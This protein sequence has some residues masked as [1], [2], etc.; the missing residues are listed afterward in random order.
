MRMKAR[1]IVGSS[2]ALAL[3]AAW[4]A[5]ALLPPPAAAAQAQAAPA[6]PASNEQLL[7]D[8]LHYVHIRNDDLAIANAN[9]LLSRGLSP[10]EFVGLV[11]DSRDGVR[12][13]EQ[14]VRLA[15][16]IPSLETPA[17]AL[18]Q[19]YENGKRAQSR[20]PEEIAQSIAMLDGSAR[21]RMLARERLKSARE[22]AVPQ[23]LQ[24]LQTRPNPLLE[25]EVT[26][27]LRDMGADVIAPLTAALPKVDPTTQERICEILGGVASEATL[28]YLYELER[29]TTVESVK[30]AARRAIRLIAGAP[31]DSTS[32]SDRFERLA[33]RYY[34]Q[35]QSLTRFPDEQHQLLWTFNPSYGLFPTP[36]RTEVFHEMRAMEIAAHAIA[37][38]PS[39]DHAVSL[40]I[41][42]NLRRE[43]QTPAGWTNPAYPASRP[44][45]EYYAAAGGSKVLQP[46][47]ARALAEKDTRL[48]RSAIKALSRSAGGATLWEGVGADKPLVRA[49]LYP[50]RRVQIDAALALARANPAE[51]FE[52]ADRVVPILAAAA[53]DAATTYALILAPSEEDRQ[54]LQSLAMELGYTA[55]APAPSLDAARRDIAEAPAVDLILM[56]LGSQT[57]AAIN[58]ARLISK[59]QVAP[60]VAQAGFTIF[61]ELTPRYENDPLVSVA[62]DGLAKEQLATAI[63]ETALAAAG[64]PITGDEASDYMRNAL[65][66]LLTL[67]NTR[68]DAF[69]VREASGPLLAALAKQTGPTRLL[70]ADVL[71]RINQRRAQIAI[72]DA[73]IHAEADDRV[74]LLERVALS[75]RRFGGLLDQTQLDWLVDTALVSDNESVATAAAALMGSLNMPEL[76]VAPLILHGA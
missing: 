10:V 20:D 72:M 68:S 42:A 56:R 23:L 35:Q 24:V 33:E 61:N 36:V 39:N 25:A 21:G 57:Q 47:L 5:V 76:Q 53:A 8:F 75:V 31:D 58:N 17:A 70:V 44:G 59:L 7:A 64:P 45:A 67:A 29:T 63:L 52:G 55:I 26:R 48:A 74:A 38:D 41:A 37:L 30:G 11:E 13:F 9:A 16:A 46:V 4:S 19:L 32:L 43:I 49:L 2:L 34:A 14:T 65:Q 69:D 6:A 71:A 3:L 62:R 40:W 18:W 15:M 28:P 73:A 60:I 66:A 54:D 12:R 22:Y 50:D 1:R 51:T 27:L